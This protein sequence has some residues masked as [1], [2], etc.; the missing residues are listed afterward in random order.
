MRIIKPL[1]IV[2]DAIDGKAMAQKIEYFTRKCYKSEGKMTPDSYDAFVRRVFRTMKHEGIIE[3]R[4]FSVTMITDRGVSHEHVRHRMASYLQEST[5]Y[6]DYSGKGVTFI[7]PPWITP[8]HPDY[9]LFL[10]DCHLAERT[11]NWWRTQR[12]WTPQ[13]ARYYLPNG[14]KTEYACTMNLGSWYNFF[15][16]RVASQAHPQ[17]R[18]LAIPLLQYVQQRLPMIFDDIEIPFY[19]FELARVVENF[20]VDPVDFE[21]VYS[22]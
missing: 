5:R 4:W 12:D 7:L 3:H 10:N 14:I 18:Q 13:Q 19:D 11:Y 8:E 15:R 21:E 20:G 6:C 16:K 22:G 2:E 17:M 1:V 9:A